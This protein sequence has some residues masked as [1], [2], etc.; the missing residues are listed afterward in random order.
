MPVEG[1]ARWTSTTTSGSSSETASEIV[2]DLSDARARGGG[3]GERPAPR[4]AQGRTGGGDLVL[5]L[6]GGDAEALV[7]GQLVEDVAGG[8]DRVRAQEHRQA[9]GDAGGGDAPR[10]RRVPGDVP[11]RAGRE[12]RRR[13][14]EPDGERLGGL[15]VVPPGLE[16]GDVRLG[17]DGLGLELA[18]QELLGGLG[19]P[20][21]HP[22]HEAEREHVLGPLGVLLGDL[23]LGERADGEGRE[24]HRVQLVVLQRAVFERVVVVADLGEVPLG[25]L[26]GVDD[27][28]P[29]GLEVPQVRLE[30]GRVHRDEHLGLV[31][32]GEDVGVRE[33]D[34]EARH[35]RQGP[36]GGPD[37]GGVV[38]EGRE[39]VAEL[40][41]LRGEAVSRELHPVAGVPCE[42][43][44][45]PV[46][47]PDGIHLVLLLRVLGRAVVAA[48]RDGSTAPFRRVQPCL[49]CDATRA[50]RGG[51]NPARRA[52][53]RR[54]HQVRLL[55]LYETS[56]P[57]E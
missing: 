46:Q 55:S 35:A 41:G 39:V 12:L 15:A 33:V 6:H 53:C 48:S 5:G 32:R 42:A 9:G 22:R 3:D 19:G 36:G 26:V 45:D 30:R 1:P 54:H 57:N 4:G 23:E 50:E 14:L 52:R 8:R 31:A 38:R 7:L 25:E 40:G 56:G 16:R 17:D 47:L 11:V 51:A 27:D 37:L 28:G 29:A 24:G 43:D 44:D 10:E 49:T 18:A 2:S 21:V 20:R 34:L 13:D